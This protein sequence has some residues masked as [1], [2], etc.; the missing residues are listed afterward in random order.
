MGVGVGLGLSVV[1]SIVAAHG[2]DVRVE[3]QLGV[4]TS[5]TVT[6]PVANAGV[7]TDPT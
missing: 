1:K 5:F 3:S 6:L 7:E 4:G 2:G